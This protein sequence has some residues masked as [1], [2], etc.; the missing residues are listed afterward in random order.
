LNSGFDYYLTKPIDSSKLAEI[1][2]HCTQH[3]SI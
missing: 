2:A 1:I 3:E